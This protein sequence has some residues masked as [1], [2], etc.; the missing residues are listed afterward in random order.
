M[1][2]LTTRV[3]SIHKSANE[4]VSRF[5]CT[6][7]E[8]FDYLP[9][10]F[11]MIQTNDFIL[12]PN[13]KPHKKA[14]S[15]W[16]TPDQTRTQGTIGFLVKQA[17][18]TGMSAYLT[19][20]L[21]IWDTLHLIGPVGHFVDTQKSTHYLLISTGSG[22]TP[23]WSHLQHLSTQTSID[24]NI[25]IAHIYGERNKESLI[26]SLT[27][28]RI[29]TNHIH[30]RLHLSRDTQ[31]WRRDWYIQASLDPALSRLGTRDCQVFICGKPVMVDD[32]IQQLTSLG[33]ASQNIHREKY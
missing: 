7:N 27:Q 20:Q 12:W 25:R 23:I 26:P 13:G 22:L 21:K 4:S 31:P 1:Q 29:N 14:Y 8:P 33:I 16:S 32:V 3:S 10:Q 17:S 24:P 9:G 15:I 28:Q 11:V 6:L 30:H 19:Q 2:T 5:E 18:E